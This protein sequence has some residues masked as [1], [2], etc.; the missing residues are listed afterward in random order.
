MNG[1]SSGDGWEYSGGCAVGSGSGATGFSPAEHRFRDMA[2][3]RSPSSS[4]LCFFAFPLT[5]YGHFGIWQRHLRLLVGRQP[6]AA[7]GIGDVCDD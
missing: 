4:S 6:S 1:F 7:L 5:E 3:G 2:W